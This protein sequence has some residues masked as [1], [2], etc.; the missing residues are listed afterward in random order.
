[1]S[2]EEV[3]FDDCLDVS[4]DLQ[5]EEMQQ[6][7]SSDVDVEKLVKA[8]KKCRDEV[9]FLKKLKKSRA[10]PIDEKI[11]KLESN[12]EKLKDF[13]IELMPEMFPTKNSVDFP[14]VGK[15]TRRK[16]KGKWSIDDDEKF[17]ET[18]KKFNEFDEAVEIKEILNKTKAKK[19]ITRILKDAKP[20]E[21]EGASYEEPENDFSLSVQLH[22]DAPEP[23][24]KA[25][26][27][28]VDDI[29]F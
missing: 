25:T 18:L 19:C 6:S 10:L 22:V 2:F 1:M 4:G 5:E 26:S 14:G 17:K 29:L 23:K 12:E 27:T 3:D 7:I 28:D 21:I 15:V 11:A 24:K 16:V 9:E 13:I 8:I 20:E